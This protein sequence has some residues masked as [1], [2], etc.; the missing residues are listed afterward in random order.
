MNRWKLGIFHIQI[1]TFHFSRKIRRSWICCKK[2]GR[3]WVVVV[4]SLTKSSTNSPKSWTVAF[5]M[6]FKEFPMWLSGLQTQLLSMRMQI[7]FLAL[8]S[9]LRIRNCRELWCRSQ[10]R[11]RSWV[12]MTVASSSNLTP[13]LG[14]SLW[15]SCGPKKKR[16]KKK[17]LLD[18]IQAPVWEMRAMRQDLR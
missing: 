2:A 18:C 10:P 17:N 5:T 7:R 6:K 13:S 8:L 16:K 14:N 11:L 15:H 3:G 4:A 1:W 12:A 9:G